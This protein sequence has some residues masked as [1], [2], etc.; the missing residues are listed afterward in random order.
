MA[1]FIVDLEVDT[2]VTRVK[3]LLRFNVHNVN[4][5]LH[6]YTN[7]PLDRRPDRLS[8]EISSTYHTHAASKP[9]QWLLRLFLHY[10]LS[11]YFYGVGDHYFQQKL[12]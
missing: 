4:I 5:F 3:I 11:A 2:L 9:F 7:L 10:I 12:R 1:N 6:N 8:R